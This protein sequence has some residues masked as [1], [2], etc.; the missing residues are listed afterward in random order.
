M[1][2]HLLTPRGLSWTRNG[3]PK[4]AAAHNILKLE[5]RNATPEDLCRGLPAEFEEFLSYTRRLKFKENPDYA[6]WVDRFRD[7]AME[8][9]FMDI[10]PFVWPPPPSTVSSFHLLVYCSFIFFQVLRSKAANTPNRMRVPALPHD[11][12][13]GILN[14]LTNLNLEPQHVLGD[15]TNVQNALRKA[16]EVAQ[17]DLQKNTGSG[18]TNAIVVR[19]GSESTVP[20]RCQPPKAVR[21]GDLSRRASTASDNQTLARLVR[22]FVEVLR[23]NSSR[24]LTREAFVFLDVLYKQLDDPS[25]FIQPARFVQSVCY[26]PNAMPDEKEI[27][28]PHENARLMNRYQRK[29]LPTLSWEWLR[30]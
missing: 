16:K 12:M 14:G 19:S 11:E 26:V 27:L 22:E 23:M 15:R 13:A 28:G 3:I 24:T 20:V 10:E 25:V 2:I 8:L 4:T 30:V 5:K 17:I 1:F 21:L 9:G 6:L 18:E 7:L 29:S